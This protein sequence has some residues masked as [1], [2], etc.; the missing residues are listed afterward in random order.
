MLPNNQWASQAVVDGIIAPR[1]KVKVNATTSSDNGPI[2][3]QNTS[4]GLMAKIWTASYNSVTGS[5]TLQDGTNLFTDVNLKELS[6]TFNQS[7]NPF[8]AFR[9]ATRIKIW[10][11]DPLLSNYTIKDVTTGD[12]PFCYL[13]ERRPEFSANSDVF[14]LYHRDGEIFYR[15]QRDRFDVEYS[16]GI[17]GGTDIVIE[18]F[19][20]AKN[21]RLQIKYYEGS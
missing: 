19:G 14:L 20:M 3:I 12:Q 4:K 21:N 13:D 5:V 9:S 7:G 2:A 6:L 1:D 15:L 18:C 16:T 17:I 11:Y 10:W 8:V